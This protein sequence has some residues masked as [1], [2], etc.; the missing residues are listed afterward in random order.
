MLRDWPNRKEVFGSG[1][2]H[3][4][5]RS[6]ETRSIA[7]FTEISKL[8]AAMNQTA[9]QKGQNRIRFNFIVLRSF[10]LP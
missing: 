10:E 4:D 1:G 2:G 8:D 9:G 6:L 3:F 5:A 7:N